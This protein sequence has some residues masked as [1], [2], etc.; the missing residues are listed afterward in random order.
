MIVFKNGQ[1]SDCVQNMTVQEFSTI[2]EADHAK[3]IIRV[4]DYKIAD[5]FGPANI[6]LDKKDF[7]RLKLFK[8]N[9]RDK[10]HSNC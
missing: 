2:V 10:V 8:V 1:R 5:L 7:E 6:V 9:I 3:Y 4:A